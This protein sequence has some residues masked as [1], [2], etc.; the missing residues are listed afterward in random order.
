MYRIDRYGSSFWAAANDADSPLR[1]TPM[2]R[3]RMQKWL[4]DCYGQLERIA[5]EL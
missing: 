4:K 5:T 3:R 1:L 2:D